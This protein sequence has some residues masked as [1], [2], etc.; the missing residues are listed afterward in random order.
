M[1]GVEHSSRL[2]EVELIVG[3][4][5]P[6]QLEDAIEPRTDPRVL[7]R[8]LAHVL[9]PVDLLV[10]RIGSLLRQCQFG[11]LGAVLTGNVAIVFAQLLA[12]RGQ[13]LTQQVLA[14]LLVDTFGDVGSNLRRDLQFGEVILC[15]GCDQVDTLR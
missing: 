1:I 8:L 15:P 12:D 7:G 14:L 9:Q 2:I 6:R 13:L 11:D 4:C 3:A 5:V 10:D